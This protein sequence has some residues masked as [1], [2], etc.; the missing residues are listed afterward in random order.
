AVPEPLPLDLP[1]PAA[2]QVKTEVREDE[3]VLQLGDRRYRVRGLTKNTGVDQLK[4]NLLVSREG[5]HP[6]AGFHVDTLDLYAARQRA[7]FIRQA[8]Q[9]M[10]LAEEVVRHDLALLR[11]SE[12]VS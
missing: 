1:S 12:G 9:E 6:N 5:G 2:P 7:A 8:A 4:V 10:G 3:V 11:Q